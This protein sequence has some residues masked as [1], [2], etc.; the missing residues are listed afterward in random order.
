[1]TPEYYKNYVQSLS[2]SLSAAEATTAD[3]TRLQQEQAL[4]QWIE[5]TKR[6]HGIGGSIFFVGNGASAM[7]ASHMASDSCKT[8]GLRTMAFNDAALLTAVSNDIA[9]E[10]SF[11]F[12][13]RVFGKPGDILI[14][15]SSSGGSKNILAAIRAA[16]EK[17]LTVITLS[18][19][20]ADNPSRTS[21]D[22]NFYIPAT[23]Y[24]HVESA[25]QALL[26]CWLDRYVE[27]T[28]S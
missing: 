9:Y 3:G 22:L 12:P 7:M 23:S 17:T 28:T 8:A 6:T 11:A 5:L 13:L 19:M 2:R 1:M 20:R 26:H 27:V 10:E 16:R 4:D 15:I 21:G 18:G 25:H 24:G 14:T